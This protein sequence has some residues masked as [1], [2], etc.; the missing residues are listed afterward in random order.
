MARS[1]RL[2]NILQHDRSGLGLIGTG[3]MA[4][5]LREALGGDL[6]FEQL[7]RPLALLA[8]D[9]RTG[10]EV[11][12]REGPVVEAI[13]ATI[14]IPFLFPPVEWRGRLL[15]DGGILN[16]VPF[17]VVREMGNETD[18][19]KGTQD[20]VRVVAVYAFRDLC[21]EPEGQATSDKRGTETIIRL[22]IRR[23]RWGPMIDMVERSQNIMIRKLVAQ[24][25]QQSPPDLLIEVIVN[26]VGL[27]DLD[28]LDVCLE[29]GTEAARRH[30]P[31]LIAL[32]DAPPP[33]LLAR[34]WHA[35]TDKVAEIRGT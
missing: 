27:L 29:A 5:L 22:L 16:Q 15:A 3:K 18:G 24:R 4:V 1:T 31:E 2:L 35:V 20:P 7:Q 10:E 26:S 12:M 8:T 28:R 17:D 13:L 11:I 32:R 23:S 30:L 21:C 9:L 33:G 25:M 6:T 14:A 19:P 34:W